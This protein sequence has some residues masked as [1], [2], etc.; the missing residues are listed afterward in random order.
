MVRTSDPTYLAGVSLR[1]GMGLAG[2]ESCSTDSY[3]GGGA[4]ADDEICRRAGGMLAGALAAA[5]TPH[6]PGHAGMR[7]GR[8]AGTGETLP[9]C[10]PCT[11]C[12]GRIC[13][14]DLAPTILLP[15][16]WQPSFT[17]V[18]PLSVCISFALR[19]DE[20]TGSSRVSSATRQAIVAA[21]PVASRL[22]SQLPQRA[23]RR[24]PPPESSTLL[25][26]MSTCLSRPWKTASTPRR[27][28]RR[29]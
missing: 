23:R 21:L 2:K 14:S 10:R 15:P 17:W 4:T 6:L 28:T 29:R 5:G 16:G 27:S 22:V 25:L 20:T 1:Q 13:A 26:L 19:W 11:S 12:G 8:R 9:C 18:G 24:L 3:L 7:G